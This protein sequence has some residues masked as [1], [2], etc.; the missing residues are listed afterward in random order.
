[1]KEE[2]KQILTIYLKDRFPDTWEEE[3]KILMAMLNS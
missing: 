2:I 1:M 3:L